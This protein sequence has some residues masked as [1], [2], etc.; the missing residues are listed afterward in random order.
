MFLTFIRTPIMFHK[1]SGL[2][3]ENCSRTVL[4]HEYR[5]DL[6]QILEQFQNCSR[7]YLRKGNLALLKFWTRKIMHQHIEN[8]SL[9]GVIFVC[10]IDLILYV[11][12]TIFQFNRD[13]SSWVELNNTSCSRTTTQWRRWGWN[14]QPLGLDLWCNTVL[15]HFWHIPVYTGRWF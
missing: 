9:F 4:E 14:L 3:I 2:I 11:P 7:T 5:N 8:H 10:L 1:C 12:S 13:R 15:A 6:E